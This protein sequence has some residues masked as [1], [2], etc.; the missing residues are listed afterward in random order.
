MLTT[1]SY[2]S[3]RL[4]SITKTVQFETEKV[5]KIIAKIER[6]AT[7]LANSGLLFQKLQSKEEGERL[8]LEYL[9]S[10][11]AAIGGGFWFEPYA[12]NKDDFRVGIYAFFDK[13]KGEIRF[14]YSDIVN[15]DYHNMN[16][17]REI[18]DAIKKPY[19]VVWTKPY[20]D[21]SSHS[22]M[23]TAG[24]GIFDSY[25]KMI[26]ISIIDW[27]IDKVIEELSAL[28]P[29][30]NSFVLLCAPEKD[31]VISST[32]TRKVIGGSIKDIPWDI[33]DDVFQLDGFTYLK[34]AVNMD[35][36]WL[37]S[38]QIPDSEIFAD[39][40]MQNNRFTLIIAFSSALMLCF[41]Y[42]LISKLINAPIMKLTTEVAQLALGNLDM[43]VEIASNDEL[44]L[45]AETFNKMA[46]DLK[47][48]ID[49]YTNEHA[50]KERI[51][52]ELNVATKIQV[53]I[54]PHIFPP[55]P[56]RTEFDIYASMLPAKEVGGDFYDFY[57]IDEN[58][59]AVVIADVSGKG[60][61]AALFMIIAKTLIKNCSSCRTPKS[62]FESVNNKLCENNDTGMFVTAF[63]GFYNIVTGRF[64]YV[65]AGHNPPLVRKSG[66][67]FEF[68][69]TEP[70][71]ILAWKKGVEYKE[72]DTTLEPG[73][74][75][76]LYT[77]GVTEA[78]NADQDL[79]SEQRL[80]NALNTYKDHMPEELISAIKQEIDSFTCGAEQA[81][82]ITMLALKVN[83]THN[84]AE[85][86]S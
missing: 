19:Q 68:L 78:M 70:G 71:L 57:F 59:L 62:I 43:R 7:D 53:S 34:F 65:S 10:F 32:R 9:H 2:K 18:F 64:V 20:I 83:N 25:G 82:D 73:D 26:G 30:K 24:A 75:L 40:E 37:L 29:T 41:S 33:N 31:Y 74:T 42:Y 54:L 11:T 14:D 58:N 39:V 50:E 4:E 3:L 5:N 6:A 51:S 81:D 1:M 80:H 15:Y 23:T 72:I 38:I 16:W 46:A 45:L 35:N 85:N 55:Y 60:I 84:T 27:E 12:Y 49:A 86:V 28:K 63:I 61:P 17:Y 48:S 66:G 22:L 44:G 8:L 69:K 13:E 47:E 56:D 52:T 79:F 76:Y 77:D 21:D 36:G 67:D